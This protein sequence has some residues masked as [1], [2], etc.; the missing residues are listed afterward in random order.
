MAGMKIIPRRVIVKRIT[1]SV[2]N[3]ALANF[4]ASSFDF[5]VKYSVKSGINAAESAPSPRS[6][7][8]KFGILNATK[9]ASVAK[10]APKIFAITISLI[11]PKIRLKNVPLLIIPV[12]LR[13]L[14]FSD[15]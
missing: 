2:E 11:K 9:K 12:A 4:Q 13:S 10:P 7:L 6:L 1:R 15:I 5:V 8:N 3:T 14:L